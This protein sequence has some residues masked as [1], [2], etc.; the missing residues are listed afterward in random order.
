MS[1][2]LS[3]WL[4]VAIDPAGNTPAPLNIRVSTVSAPRMLWSLM[5][6]A[7][8]FAMNILKLEKNIGTFSCQ[9]LARS[10]RGV[11]TW[12]LRTHR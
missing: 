7:I 12:P 2:S 6:L 8:F 5:Y 3:F 11:R 4:I 1:L 10:A 9:Y